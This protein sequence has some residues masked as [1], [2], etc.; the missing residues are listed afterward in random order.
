MIAAIRGR[1][2]A[3]GGDR[4]V[5]ETSGGVSYEI[6]VPL[7]VFERL[8]ATGEAV[9]LATELVVREDGWALYGFGDQQ[10]RRF[11]QRLLGVTGVGPRLALA[12]LSGLGVERAARAVQE[13]NVTLL[14]SVSGI[15]RKTAERLTLE[16]ADKVGEF[17]SGTGGG[18][19]GGAAAAALTALERLGY[20]T[21]DADRAVRR[22]L[23]GDGRGA[24]D[25]ADPEAL[26]RRALA[27]L[28]NG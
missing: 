12:L 14:A 19:A 5:V 28:V 21:A 2:A 16:L 17:V 15:G 20:P 11:F 1:L 9:T 26:V 23:T 22:A 10:Q 24:G 13:R 3:K 7:G 8:P 6:V 4:V 18:L 25:E 27:I